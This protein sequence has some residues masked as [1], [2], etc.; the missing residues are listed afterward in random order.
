MED[1]QRQS[2][3]NRVR[4][5]LI[6]CE[7]RD[8]LKAAVKMYN[9]LNRKYDLTDKEVRKLE[10]IVGL[11]RKKCLVPDEDSLREISDIGQQFR[12]QAGLSGEPELNRIKFDED[13]V[14]GGL[15]DNMTPEKLAK[16]HDVS[17]EDIKKEI[18]V[19]T[20]IEM[21]HTDSKKMAKEIAMDHI[22]EIAD[23]YTDPQY[24]IIAI[25]KKQGGEKKTIRISKSEMEKLHDEGKVTVDGIELSYP[26]EEG[27]GATSSG[28]FVGKLGSPITRTFKKSEIPVSKNGLNK[29]VGKMTTLTEEDPEVDGEELEEATDAS[30]SGAYVTN[31]VWAKGEKDW[32]G[33]HK[34]TYKGGKFVN[35]K[36]KC[37]NYPYCD[38]GPGAIEL[39]D[40]SN[41]K[42]DSVFNESRVIKK[43][44]KG[45]LKIKK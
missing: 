42:V 29:P 15:A 12:T 35:V 4:D 16:K 24:G 9:L 20:K 17:V 37:K 13:E 44:K 2:D 6:S 10:N 34:K 36:E 23:Y 19:G 33:K 18:S 41:M 38:E 39:S 3:Y 25:E 5:V 32:R 11:M 22:A 14:K 30:S 31:K 43:V 40:T 7:N 28:S 1:T 21:E 8:Q 27:T 26:V 45:Q